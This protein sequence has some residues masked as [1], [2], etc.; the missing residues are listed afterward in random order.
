MLLQ[1]VDVMFN[2]IKHAFFQPAENEMITILHFH[3][4]NPIMI[5]K[6]KTYDVQ[7]YAEVME[8]VQTLDNSRR[9]M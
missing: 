3:L 1:P 7:F 2:N 4:K 5:G 6:K 8:V 9:A